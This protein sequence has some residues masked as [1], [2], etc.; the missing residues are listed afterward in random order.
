MKRNIF[1]SPAGLL[2]LLACLT[3]N[4]C[5][6]PKKEDPIR[7][8]PETPPVAIDPEEDEM[9][10]LPEYVFL[11]KCE[12]LGEWDAGVFG[13]DGM[14][15]LFRFKDDSPA[16]LVIWDGKN[17][18]IQ[19]N[20]LFDGDGLPAV[21]LSGE[22]SFLVSNYRGNRFDL[23]IIC[24]DETIFSDSIES[25]TDWDEYRAGNI[26]F[27][28]TRAT[29]QA[30]FGRQVGAVVG[31]VGAAILAAPAIVALA[32]AGVTVGTLAVA[33]LA[34]TALY[35]AS[36]YAYQTFSCDQC[37]A[38]PGMAGTVVG[39]ASGTFN[40][41]TKPITSISLRDI[42]RGLFT[43][44]LL[45]QVG[46]I[47]ERHADFFE[48][49][50]TSLIKRFINQQL[51]VNATV[52]EVERES[53]EVNLTLQYIDPNSLNADDGYYDNEDILE[54]LRTAGIFLSTSPN[55]TEDDHTVDHKI[56]FIDRN[57]I[58]HEGFMIRTKPITGLKPNTTYYYRSYYTYY[59]DDYGIRTTQYGEEKSFKTKGSEVKVTLMWNFVADVDVH[60][61]EPS[62]FE[63]YYGNKHSS[64]GGFLDYD[65]VVAFGP[66]NI[67]WAHAP[68]GVYYVYLHHFSGEN[69]GS[70]TVMLQINGQYRI[71]R[72]FIGVAQAVPITYFN[73][74]E[75]IV[76]NRSMEMMDAKNITISTEKKK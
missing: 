36:N 25:E 29:S 76:E 45:D 66:E 72:G 57:E 8:M 28:S 40:D 7:Q 16:E 27:L 37:A 52:I 19:S 53:A 68:E 69:A 17:D 51:L 30:A 33:A 32:T 44:Y 31:F 11:D 42:S 21:I 47:I 48:R 3:L 73:P 6:D 67:Y 65:N 14:T 18:L 35:I 50:N 61:I 15:Q 55:P 59:N 39:V 34:V 9:I 54:G 23:D 5:S 4:T 75:G 13:L 12:E 60:I 22:Y 63:I 58:L 43:Q 38:S 71:F 20:V 2:L 46:K 1:I 74:E 64:T 56:E 24:G 70:Y 62:G 49:A 41:G 10:E 26:A